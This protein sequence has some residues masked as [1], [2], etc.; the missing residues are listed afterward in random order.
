M[1]PVKDFAAFPVHREISFVTTYSQK[2]GLLP[3]F[4]IIF[5]CRKMTVSETITPQRLRAD[6]ATKKEPKKGQSGKVVFLKVWEGANEHLFVEHIRR[7]FSG[8][9]QTRVQMYTTYKLR[10]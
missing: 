6:L 3:I 5:Q 9:T 7:K 8:Q 1:K 2:L 10:K 4:I